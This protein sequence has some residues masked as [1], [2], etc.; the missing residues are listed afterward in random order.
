MR[1]RILP[2]TQLNVSEV[3]LGTMTW[4]EQNSQTEAHA[5]LDYAIAQG[6][7][8][9]DTA[10]MYPVPP[11]AKTQGRTETFLGTWL[12]RRPRNGLVIATKVAGP[13]RRDWIRNGRT[14]LTREVIAE[15]VDTSLAR[16]QIDHIDLYQIHWPQ[17][18]VPN[19]GATA[20][21]PAKEKTGPSIREQVE[22]MAAVIESG[23]IRH[24]G[25]SNETAWGVCEFRRVARELG[26]P[27]PVTIQNSYSL[28]SR[29]VDNDLAEALFREKM[30]L[31]AYSP[32]AAGM[33]SGKYLGGAQPPKARFTLFDGLGL[34][35]RKPMVGEAIEAYAALAKR[36]NVSLVQ[37]ALGYVRSRWYLGAS[38]LGATTMAQLE[39]DIA[40]AQ[41]ELDA[42]MLAE[43]A[44]VQA[45]Y[46][47]PAG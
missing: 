17:R 14:D 40:A 33:L 1:Y 12:A 42:E 22:G 35:F 19:F 43:I 44:A 20:F 47:N 30:S 34:R 2:G 24:Y 39:E 21:D 5:Q 23:K 45:R 8:F 31:L 7:N 11:N 29:N 9:I 37:L 38:I 36:R 32:L 4:G 26:V 18:N 15:A 27:G 41:F 16:L 25:L 6:I 28:V 10:E 3:C 46:P 13:G